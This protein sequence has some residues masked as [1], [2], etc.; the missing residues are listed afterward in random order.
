MNDADRAQEN[1]Q[2]AE[3]SSWLRERDPAKA[4]APGGISGRRRERLVWL[5]ER[6]LLAWLARRHRATAIAGALLAL[7]AIAAALF[8]VRRREGRPLPPV[9]VALEDPAA[10]APELEPE[11]E[12]VELPGELPQ[13]PRD[14]GR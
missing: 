6:P 7:A 4:A 9:A 1:A 5:M 3:I 11:Y 14:F 8:A 13:T 10:A 2:W 12:P